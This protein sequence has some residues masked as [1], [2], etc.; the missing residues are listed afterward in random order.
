MAPGDSGFA[1]DVFDTGLRDF[2]TA[3]PVLRLALAVRV[4]FVR[5]VLS[6]PSRL[7]WIIYH[8]DAAI[9]SRRTPRW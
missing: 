3:V 6:R 7:L 2:L 4:A 5:F 9:G 1:G 8:I